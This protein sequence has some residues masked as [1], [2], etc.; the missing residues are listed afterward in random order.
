MFQAGNERVAM[1]T[2]G[3]WTR[4]RQISNE[5][6][7]RNFERVFGKNPDSRVG[8]SGDSVEDNC[9]SGDRVGFGVVGGFTYWGGSEQEVDDD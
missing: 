9:N 5:E 8:V 7:D 2:K 4:K 3:D 6:W 1:G